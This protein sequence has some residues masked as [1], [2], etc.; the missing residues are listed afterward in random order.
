MIST[1]PRFAEMNARPVTHAGSLAAGQ[2]EVQAG[3]DLASGDEADAENEDEVDRDKQV[4]EP[5]EI[6][7]QHAL[8][9]QCRGGPTHI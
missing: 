4:V 7:A 2:E 1:A 9:S 6:E 3:R 5:S 8:G